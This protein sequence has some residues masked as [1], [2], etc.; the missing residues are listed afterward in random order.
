M[1]KAPRKN[2]G[3]HHHAGLKGKDP[4]P[5]RFDLQKK[6]WDAEQ[7]IADEDLESAIDQAMF[8]GLGE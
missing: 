7:G 2:T 5:S 1:S 8:Y 3:Y 6:A 4:R